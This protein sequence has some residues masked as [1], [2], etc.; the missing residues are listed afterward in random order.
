MWYKYTIEYY[1]VLKKKDPSAKAWI[2]IENT[3]LSDTIQTENNKYYVN[4]KNDTN[5]SIHK[6][7]KTHRNRKQIYGHQ[8]GEEGKEGQIRIMRL[9]NT[10]YHT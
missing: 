2:D 6:I 10:N 4:I 7:E 1:S 9:T 3:V 8:T 5:E